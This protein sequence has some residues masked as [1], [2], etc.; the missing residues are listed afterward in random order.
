MDAG[1]IFKGMAWTDEELAYLK[2]NYS[3]MPVGL[4]AAKLRRTESSVRVRASQM[5]LVSYIQCCRVR[6]AEEADEIREYKRS[7]ALRLDSAT[8]FRLRQIS[9]QTGRPIHDIVSS[10]VTDYVKAHSAEPVDPDDT[11]EEDLAMRYA[12]N[13]VSG[14]GHM[15]NHIKDLLTD[16]A[17]KAFR[18]GYNCKHNK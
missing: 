11:T 3:R 5:R 10:V 18:A 17:A 6:K 15:G 2:D 16:L 1:V 4:L 12:V 9:V 13:E 8:K 7:I 14:K